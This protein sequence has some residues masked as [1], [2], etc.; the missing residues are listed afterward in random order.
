MHS[1]V[2]Q[3]GL[4]RALIAE[5]PPLLMAFGI[6]DWLYKFHSFALET[7]AF[8]VTWYVLSTLYQLLIRK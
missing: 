2:K 5:S 3:I 1:L 7:I 4:K 6:A 8:L